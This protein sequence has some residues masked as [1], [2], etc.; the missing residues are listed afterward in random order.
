MFRNAVA[1]LANSLKVSKGQPTSAPVE[2][3]LAESQ[4]LASC[5]IVT[6]LSDMES[7]VPEGTPLSENLA[8]RIDRE[9]KLWRDRKALL[10]ATSGVN[11]LAYK[12]MAAETALKSE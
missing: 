10:D 8:A 9:V 5:V 6:L 4:F 12:F 11:T 3:T 7:T 1:R 2:I